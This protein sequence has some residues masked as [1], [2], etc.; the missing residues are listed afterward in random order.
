MVLFM[1]ML[2][3][4][5]DNVVC[6]Y[7]SLYQ[8][9]EAW[10]PTVEGL[11]FHSIGAFDSAQLERKFDREEVVSVLKDLKGDKAPGP[12]G[13]SMAFFHK[14]W[15]IVGDDVMGFFEEFHTHCKF[16]KSLNATFIALIPKKWDALNIR[17]YRP[18][19]LISS[20]Y[21]LLSK[22]LANRIKTVLELLISD[23][24]NAFVGGRQTL[25][26]VLIANEC[27]DSR[28][29]SSTLGI[30]CKL[31]IEK[32]YDHVN[33]DCLL[34]LLV[35][36]GFGNR[37]CQWI[38]TCIST[39]Q[40]SVLVNGS[41]EGFFGNS[42][43]LRQGDPLSP[44]LFLLVMEVL[45]KMFK[46]SEEAG[47]ICGFMAGV[48]GG[49]EVRISHLLFA[50]DTIV[51]CDAVPQQVMHIRKVLSCFEAV[52]GLK[53]NLTKS[54]MVPVGVV[55]NMPY[56]ADL[57]CCR[58]GAL[59]MLYLGMPLGAP[60]KGLSVWNSGLSVW[61][62]VLEKIERRLASWQTLYLSKGGRLTLLKSTL[63]SLPTYFLSLFTIPVS[64][65]Q[66]IEKLQRNF[67]WGGMGDGVKYHLPFWVN[68]YGV[69][70]LKSLICGGELLWQNMGWSGGGWRS[71]HCRG[72][73]G[74]GLWKSISSGWDG[75]SRRI[76]YSVGKGDRIRFWFDKW[77][78]QTWMTS[79]AWNISFLRDFNDWEMPEVLSFFNFIQPFLPNRETD[80]KLVWPL[81][82][83]GKFDVR[84]YYGALQVPLR[85][86]FPWKIIWGVKAPRRI[87]FF[88][89]TAAC[90]KILTC[91]N[92]MRR[93]HVL[94][95]WCCMCKKGW[96][97][98]DHLLI[99]CEVAAALWGFVFQR[100]GIQWVL[101]AKRNS[102]VFEDK[103]KSLLQLQ[104]VFVGLLYDCSRT[105]GFTTASS[106]PEFAVS[107][108]VD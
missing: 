33:W 34:Y 101:P 108:Y 70:G 52:T 38:K 11:D 49:S 87:S 79:C 31:D 96:E 61:N 43:G 7:E 84:S 59:P 58:I 37:W 21:K 8:E 71:K 99:H 78:D 10:R 46:K 69:L 20:M 81:R 88:I 102:R 12:D 6:F 28:L 53:V 94:A 1:K 92:L 89:W 44:L 55:D 3:E 26:S 57:L 18:I 23:S 82:K 35:R 47:L 5:R 100:F 42:R 75:F 2:D 90:G 83:S 72:T 27:L 4:V 60:Y 14:C 68:G 80:D 67:L 73:H 77:C 51:F 103:E 54:E 29:K 30:L 22:V 97:T 16:E 107:F 95:A 85:S 15:D 105:W 106:L 50:D 32:A 41:P 19:S 66:R 39:V 86:R 65:A 13:F 25:D 93:G 9:K 91:D 76:E 40:F 45:S 36:M 63:S 64:V 104:E 74:C 62:S 48:L 98:V 24:Q 56:L 17:D